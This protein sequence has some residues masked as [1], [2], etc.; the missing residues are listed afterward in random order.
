MYDSH[1]SSYIRVSI[2]NYAISNMQWR[3]EIGIFNAA[4]NTKYFK[5]KS[6]RIA[7]PVFCYSSFGFRFVFILLILFI[8][9]DIE[10]NPGPKNRKSCYNFSICHWNLNSITAH[11]FTKLNLLQAYNAILD[12]DMICLSE[13]YL[14]SSVSSDNHHQIIYSKLNLKIEYPPSYTCKIW[15]YNKS[16]TDLINHSIESFDW[17]KLL[18][19]KNVHNN[20]SCLKV[21]S[22]T[23]R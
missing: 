16:E 14:Y 4:S 18:S 7:A 9:G 23:K 2:T 22:A 8:C 10:L 21:T 1:K 3:V 19:D 6:L 17:S 5:K 20:L 15:D 13:S 12:F 11:N